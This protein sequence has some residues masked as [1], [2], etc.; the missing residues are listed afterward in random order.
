MDDLLYKVALTRIPQVGPL[1]AQQLVA[2]CGGPAAVFQATARELRRVPGIGEQR[3]RFIAGGDALQ[4]A[5]AELGLLEQHGIDFLF[6]LDDHYPERLRSLPNAPLALY[7]KGAV[8]LNHLRTVGVVGTRKPSAFGVAATEQLIEGLQAYQP[9]IISGLAYGIDGAAHRHALQQGLPTLGVLGHGLGHLYPAAHRRLAQDMLEQGGLLTEFPFFTKPE[10]EFFPMRNRI[11]AGLCDALVVVE[12]PREGGSIITAE[13]ANNYHRDVFA[14]P[15]RVH[16]KVS[17]GCN[18]LIKTHRASLIESAEDLAQLL[19]WESPVESQEQQ[20]S[21]F[22]CLSEEE[23][24][25]VD[26]LRANDKLHIDRLTY[27]SRMP[28]AALAAVLLNL[29]CQGLVKV[30]PG[31]RYVLVR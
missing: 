3:A 18:W 29:E 14:F 16:E 22:D 10:R 21:L 13:M 26:L 17:E 8:S 28:S 27:E 7:Y 23:K 20:L 30:L 5:E 31:K 4:L 24:V 25:I 11:V 12:S 2:Y 6:F 19:R 15:G 9:L 1:L